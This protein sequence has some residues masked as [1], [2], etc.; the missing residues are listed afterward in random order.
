MLSMRLFAE[1]SSRMMNCIALSSVTLLFCEDF[2]VMRPNSKFR[3]EIFRLHI[4]FFCFM[5]IREEISHK[6]HILYVIQDSIQ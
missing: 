3:G 4:M 5:Y 2:I 1:Y 6:T